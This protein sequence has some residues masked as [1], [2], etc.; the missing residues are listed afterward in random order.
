MIVAAVEL[1]SAINGQ[2]TDLGTMVVDNISGGG[3]RRD[4][5]CRMYRKGERAKHESDWAMVRDAKSTRE[6]RVLGHRATAEPVQNLIAKA[7]KE[8]GYG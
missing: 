7:L 6:A 1:L 8:M 3:A 4:Y 2:R 5:R